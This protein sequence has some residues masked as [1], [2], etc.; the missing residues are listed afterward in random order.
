LLYLPPVE[1][2]SGLRLALFVACATIATF[3]RAADTIY[4]ATLRDNV[5][6]DTGGALYSVDMSTHHASLVAPLR[7]GGAVPIGLTGLAIHPKTGVFY[8]ITGG[9]SPN[10]P[11]SLVTIDPRTGNATLV[12]KLGFS[13]SDIRFDSKGTLYAWLIDRNCLGVIDLGTGA[14]RPVEGSTYEQTLGG[15]IAVNHDGLVYIS[16]NSPGGTLDTFDPRDAK[17]VPGPQIKNAPYVSSINS[18]AFG[19][20]GNL[21]AVNSNLGTPAKTRLIAIDVKTGEAKDLMP[22]PD[23]VDSLAFG[24]VIDRAASGTER[25]RERHIVIGAICLVVG[26]LL[27]FGTGAWRRRRKSQPVSEISR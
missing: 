24:P 23:D 2:R 7:I 3:S 27:G 9:V 22:L 26:F 4:V 21:Y 19:D 12:G 15:G 13:A 17:V 25:A 16:A 10:L 18:M 14:A 6:D 11:K 20:D 5:A 1:F 8:G